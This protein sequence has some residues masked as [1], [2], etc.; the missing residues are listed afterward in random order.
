MIKCQ[1][2]K[3]YSMFNIVQTAY[4]RHN[5]NIKASKPEKNSRGQLMT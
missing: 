5:Q 4:D 1:P 3:Q 2:Q